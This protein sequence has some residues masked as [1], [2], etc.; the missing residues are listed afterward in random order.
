MKFGT[1]APRWS[2]RIWVNPQECS[3]RILRSAGCPEFASS[4]R[5]VR[6]W[7]RTLP[8]DG[9]KSLALIRHWQYGESW[10]DSGYID[11]LME[12]I[13]QGKPEDGCTSLD[14]ICRRCA[15]LD[16]TFAM[17]A[18]DGR[19]RTRQELDSSAFREYG[20]V[21]ISISPTG[22]LVKTGG[23]NHRF[24]M[25]R[26]LSIRVIPAQLGVIHRDALRQLQLLRR[27]AGAIPQG[28]E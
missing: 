26:I 9:A 25:A 5:V 7:P 6:Y 12:R 23:G 15:M 27:P 24:V 18:R 11:L 2:E 1:L 19:L 22:A 17:I 10:S 21:T 14:A 3:E 13:R 8:V 28:W 16:A 4:G 20:G